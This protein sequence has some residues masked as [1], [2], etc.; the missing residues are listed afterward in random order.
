LI[1]LFFSHQQQRKPEASRSPED[2]AG[3]ARVKGMLA[4]PVSFS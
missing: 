4:K 3:A 1:L 2:H